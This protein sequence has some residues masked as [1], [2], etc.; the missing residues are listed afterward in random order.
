MRAA[1]FKKDFAQPI[2]LRLGL[3][4][5]ESPDIIA[6]LTEKLQLKKLIRPAKNQCGAVNQQR[7]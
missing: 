5:D 6:I 4:R 3:R 2:R 1:L 7:C